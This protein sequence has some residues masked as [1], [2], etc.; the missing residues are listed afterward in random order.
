MKPNPLSIQ[1]MMSSLFINLQ[2]VVISV[3]STFY[4]LIMKSDS[5]MGYFIYQH[6]LSIYLYFFRK[7][8]VN[9]GLL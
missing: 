5:L 3:L 6:H 9:Q 1:I 4:I 2:Q 7:Q 8:Q